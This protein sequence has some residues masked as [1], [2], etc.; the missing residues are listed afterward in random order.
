MIIGYFGKKGELGRSKERGVGKNGKDNV[1][2]S[3]RREH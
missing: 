3:W 2:Y 1:K